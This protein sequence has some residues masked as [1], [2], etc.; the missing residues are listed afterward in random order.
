MGR[1]LLL[2][3]LLLL[4]LLCSRNVLAV[5]QLGVSSDSST[6]QFGV[7]IAVPPAIDRTLD[8]ASFAAEAWI[9]LGQGPS[10]GVALR[11][12]VQ[13]VA[14][15]LVLAT[16]G[17]RVHAVFRLE[18]GIEIVGVDR[19]DVAADRVL[20]LD[21]VSRVLKG[22]PLDAVVVLP[23]HQRCRGRNGARSSVGIGRSAARSACLHVRRHVAVD[24][25][26]RSRGG[27]L[28]GAS[29]LR[30]RWSL[31]RRLGK[32]RWWTRVDA[33]RLGVRGLHLARMGDE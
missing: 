33:L 12:I 19:L 15:I 32:L 30:G 20:H 2:L 14:S 18:L 31:Q 7:L 5:V 6:S 29:H 23:D 13:A 9:E 28:D 24:A 26:G 3:M 10:H 11:F 27:I 21:S 17:A 4:L 1:M 25:R 8:Q 16:A 22:N